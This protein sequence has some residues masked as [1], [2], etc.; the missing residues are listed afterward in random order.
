M[1]P[2]SIRSQSIL[3]H[4]VS[5]AKNGEGQAIIDDA[6]GLYMAVYVDIISDRFVSVA[7]YG[8]QNGDRMADPEM[9]FYRG[10]DDLYYPVSITN[11]YIGVY[12][13]GVIFDE[14]DIIISVDAAEQKDEVSFADLW[15]AN[16]R[17]Q[18]GLP[19]T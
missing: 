8:D 4:L 1:I 10:T 2:M 14:D 19:V 12:R 6:P 16:I 3:R 9:V 17:Q 15:M 13:E 18:Q 7:H 5:L 11:H